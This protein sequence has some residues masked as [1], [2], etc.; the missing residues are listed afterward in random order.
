MLFRK[1]LKNTCWALHQQVGEKEKWIFHWWN[2]P[3][4]PVY[5]AHRPIR[6]TM[7]FFVRNFR[8]KWWWMYFNFSN[9]LTKK[10]DC[11]IS[12]Y[13][14]VSC[15]QAVMPD[16]MIWSKFH[17]LMVKMLYNSCTG[18][19]KFGNNT[20]PRRIRH[21]SNLGHIFLKK[22]NCVLWAGKYGICQ[23]GLYTN[24]CFLSW[25]IM[26]QGKEKTQ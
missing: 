3:Y 7:I 8:K 18:I 13:K 21:R 23:A 19:Y 17:Y 26:M 22:K 24:I 10:Q 12:C 25:K 6:H 14:K 9:L 1:K 5:K 15:S 2:V 11:Y 4:F 16:L 20:Y